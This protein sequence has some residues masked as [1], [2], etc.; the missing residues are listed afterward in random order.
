M[1]IGR[2]YSPLPNQ[3]TLVGY[4]DAWEVIENY[5]RGTYAVLDRAGHH[6]QIEQPALFHS[7]VNEWPDRVEECW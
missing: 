1:V 5:P 6:L 7:L 3:N 4:R 2:N